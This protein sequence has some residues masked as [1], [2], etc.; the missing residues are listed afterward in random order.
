MS[1]HSSEKVDR[2][3]IRERPKGFPIMHQNWGKLLFMHWRIDEEKL[4]PLIPERLKIDTFDGSAWIGVIPFTMWNVRLS[5]T[6]PVPWLS[7][8]HEINV[9]TYVH[10]EGVPGVWFFSL[11]ANSSVAVLG[12]RTL[13]NLP[14]FNARINLEQEGE[15]I[16]YSSSRTD[17][18]PADFNATWTIEDKLSLSD[19]DSLDFYLTER[20]CLYSVKG[21]RLNRLRI[22][23]RPWP[24][25]TATVQSYS[26]TMIESHGLPTPEGEPVL[27]YAEELEV[28]FWSPDE[29]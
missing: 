1:N 23:H 7:A 13:Y 9:R 16:D 28:D 6:P 15:R 18:P 26:S 17:E 10:Y 8:F 25:Q 5:F 14:Y 29:V 11:D 2:L 24:L 3:A 22:H 19:P 20:Y 4:R 21:E 27:H 12:A